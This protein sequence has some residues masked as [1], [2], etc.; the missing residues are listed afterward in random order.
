MS[1]CIYCN[2]VFSNISSLGNHQRTAKYCLK[3]QGTTGIKFKCTSCNIEYTSKYSL[4]NHKLIC[5]K[6]L[7][8]AKMEEYRLIYEKEKNMYQV[9]IQTYKDLVET[10][11]DKLENVALAGVNKSTKTNIINVNLDRLAT[12]DLTDEKI[13]QVFDAYFTEDILID[14]IDSF[15]EMVNDKLL[16]TDEGEHMYICTDSSRDIFKRRDMFGNIHRDKR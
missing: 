11:Q 9:Q 14:G 10:L 6:Y 15:A 1:T 3:L 4:E 5:V 16:I 8:D 12:F 13:E 7:V 2:K